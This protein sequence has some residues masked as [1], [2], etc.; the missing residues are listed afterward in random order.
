[1]ALNLLKRTRIRIESTWNYKFCFDKTWL[2]VFYESIIEK[3][4]SEGLGV[5]L[6]L[7]YS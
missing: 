3:I 5:S 6:V 7:F 2:K 4:D 1:M